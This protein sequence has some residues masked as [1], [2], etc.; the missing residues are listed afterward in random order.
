MATAS[1]AEGLREVLR[2]TGYTHPCAAMDASGNIYVADGG[3]NRVIKY[4]PQGDSLAAVSGTGWEATQFDVPSGIGL[5]GVD[6][7]VTDHGNH[8]V[9]RF[10]RNLNYV[11]SLSTRESVHETERFG[12]PRGVA[13]SL[14]G[15]L[16]V[17]DGENFRIVKVTPF[18]QVERTFGST[19]AGGL[20]LIDPKCI[21]VES[22]GIV[23]VV[24]GGT[25][26]RFDM[27]GTPR[28]VI[29]MMHAKWCASSSDG[30]FLL[31]E[32]SIVK[33]PANGTDPIT[34][35]LA[36]PSLWRGMAA[37]G[38]KIAL[39]DDAEVVIYTIRP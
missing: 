33:Y 27:F 10:D 4:G 29:A 13:V 1:H 7:F 9:Q 25:V 34:I 37:S 18:N 39:W 23:D 31:T 36:V 21:C 17:L 11:A 35:P 14:Q 19:D 38:S 8:R 24:D 5:R 3:A 26:K 22:S 28:G 12:Y 30:L 32:S 20:R 2:L 15:D 6:C 16:Y